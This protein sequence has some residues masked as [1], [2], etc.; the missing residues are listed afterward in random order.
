MTSFSRKGFLQYVREK[1][2]RIN[3]YFTRAWGTWIG[4]LFIPL[5]TATIVYYEIQFVQNIFN[6]FLIFLMIFTI[7]LIAFLGIFGWIDMKRVG[8]YIRESKLV[9]TKGPYFF[10]PMPKEVEIQYPLALATAQTL[11]KIAEKLELDTEELSQ[12]MKKVD[13]YIHGSEYKVLYQ[14]FKEYEK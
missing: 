10:M 13:L 8:T 4:K 11:K 5:S 12:V 9:A 6:S 3:I 1:I 2:A 14:I 7:L